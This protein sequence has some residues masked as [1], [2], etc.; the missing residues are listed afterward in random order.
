MIRFMR[1]LRFTR[2]RWSSPLRVTYDPG[3]DAAYI[4]L[5]GRWV[6]RGRVT[7]PV[8]LDDQ[9]LQRSSS[10]SKTVA[11]SAWRFSARR[12]AFPRTFSASPKSV[13]GDRSR[14]RIG[15]TLPK[16]DR[17][18]ASNAAAHSSAVPSSQ[19]RVKPPGQAIG[20]SRGAP[21][22]RGCPET[23]KRTP[24]SRPN[25][26]RPSNQMGT[27]SA[28]PPR[29]HRWTWKVTHERSWSPSGSFESTRV[30]IP[31]T[32]PSNA[33]ARWRSDL[34]LYCSMALTKRAYRRRGFLPPSRGGQCQGLGL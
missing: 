24:G 21:P 1:M 23:S 10:T 31:T 7:V 25:S 13:S 17:V 8:P 9:D 15:C 30:S 18:H 3:A 6:S 29:N 2:R 26:R 12:T 14:A 19:G 5:T 11:S 27:S 32:V 20:L 16:S 33:N 22:Q 34:T 28:V 4:Y